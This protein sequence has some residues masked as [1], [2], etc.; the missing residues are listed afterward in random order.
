MKLG[1]YAILLYKSLE[2]RHNE[3]M[4]ENVTLY[5]NGLLLHNVTIRKPSCKFAS[6]RPVSTC[7]GHAT[8]DGRMSSSVQT[9]LGFV[10]AIHYLVSEF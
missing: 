8:G 3:Y 2:V 1:F 7:F 5:V 6:V 4:C 9:V 10:A